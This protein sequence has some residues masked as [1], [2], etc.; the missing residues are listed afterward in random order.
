MTVNQLP[1]KLQAIYNA[2]LIDKLSSGEQSS[3]GYNDGLYIGSYAAALAVHDYYTKPRK[4]DTAPRGGKEQVLL[5]Y[6]TGGWL[7]LG[8]WSDELKYWVT[9]SDP[10][11]D[12]DLLGWLP[13][14][15]GQLF[16][17]KK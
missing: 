10:C 12:D 4:M 2:L 7:V 15:E 5:V 1:E 6:K 16:E 11:Y 13:P 8:R 3:L 14:R 9:D 17:A